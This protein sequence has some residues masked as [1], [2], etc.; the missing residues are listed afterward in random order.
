MKT[1]KLFL[2]SLIVFSSSCTQLKTIETNSSSGFSQRWENISLSETQISLKDGENK[3]VSRRVLNL[4]GKTYLES[5]A[6]DGGSVMYARYNKPKSGKYS[7]IELLKNKFQQT[8]SFKQN[9]YQLLENSIEEK[10]I[11]TN[12]LA[13]GL[14]QADNKPHCLFFVSEKKTEQYE[15]AFGTYCG[16][17]KSSNPNTL[18]EKLIKN[19]ANKVA[20]DRGNHARNQL[21]TKANKNLKKI[22]DKD[23]QIEKNKPTINIAGSW[24][25]GDSIFIKARVSDDSGINAIWVANTLI[26]NKKDFFVEIKNS[27]INNPTLTAIDI[28][29]NTTKQK[30]NFNNPL[31]LTQKAEI[32]QNSTTGK[33]YALVIAVEDYQNKEQDF[34]L[35]T[36]NNDAIL[37]RNILENDYNFEVIT[38]TNPTEKSFRQSLKD[39]GEKLITNDRVLVY[40][41]G[42]G[43][44]YPENAPKNQQ[45]SYWLMSDFDFDH[46][47]RWVSDME[48]RQIMSKIP[49]RQVMLVSDSCYSG[50]LSNTNS[51]SFNQIDKNS[52]IRTVLTS[53]SDQPVPDSF[54]KTNS[55]FAIAF[56]EGLKRNVSKKLSGNELYKQVVNI[57]LDSGNFYQQPQYG[58]LVQNLHQNGNDFLLGNR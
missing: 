42:H 49:A 54:N 56:V 50:R 15:V 31:Q 57:M 13:Y 46:P 52:I 5:L 44:L 37:V 23:I 21:F 36:P 39:L 16:S 47:E 19:I 48:L 51:L 55:P 9:N 8:K 2:I 53:G 26:K 4:E 24:K 11:E 7:T 3:V 58:E 30:L 20:F 27:N 33:N 22:H 45:S 6:L 29:G 38:L 41:A 17:G 25:K 12:H 34:D 35:D 43:Y 32:Y 10:T 18:K 1:N 40:Y 28:Y 14:L